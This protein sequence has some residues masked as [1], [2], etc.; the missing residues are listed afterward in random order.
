[1]SKVKLPQYDHDS[2]FPNQKCLS[3]SQVLRYIESPQKFYLEYV[4][5]VR[6]PQSKAM[7]VGSIFSALHEFRDFPYREALR[8]VYGEK[9]SK[10]LGDLFEHVIARFP[11]VEAEKPF[12][13]EYRGWKFRVTPDG[14]EESVYTIIENKTGSRPWTQER[15]NFSQQVTMQAWAHEKVKGVIPRRII[16]NWVDTRANAKKKLHTFNTTRSK[17]AIN[18]FEK[19]LDVV[20]DG[21]EAENWT[22]SIV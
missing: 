1:M 16:L 11:V 4:L 22:R 19:L 3:S 5:G 10:R 7:A 12:W 17:K 8:E 2:I 13:A 6:R 14:Y 15:V 9:A 20:I 21:I 18:N